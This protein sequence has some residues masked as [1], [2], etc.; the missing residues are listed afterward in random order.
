MDNEPS[1]Y[2]VVALARY[3]SVDDRGYDADCK[4]AKKKSR[5]FFQTFRISVKGCSSCF[6]GSALKQRCI[7]AMFPN[8]RSIMAKSV[9]E[10]SAVAK[11]ANDAAERV[12]PARMH[13]F[14]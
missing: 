9:K 12:E 7:M 14:L 10:L 2:E 3:C 11:K 8:A 4:D 13:G 5:V 1:S 6:S